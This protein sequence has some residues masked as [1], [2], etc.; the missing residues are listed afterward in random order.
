MPK[1]HFSPHPLYTRFLILVKKRRAS[2]IRQMGLG[3]TRIFCITQEACM[4]IMYRADRATLFT[5]VWGSMRSC[6]MWENA[7]TL[8]NDLSNGTQMQGTQGRLRDSCRL[9]LKTGRL[10]T[11]HSRLS[12][13]REWNITSNSRVN[14]YRFQE[15]TDSIINDGRKQQNML[16]IRVSVLDSNSSYW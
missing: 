5:I 3:G 7:P 6:R 4:R 9:I 14:G 1:L 15:I 2:N 16:H 12:S 11:Q 8:I 10:G 13:S